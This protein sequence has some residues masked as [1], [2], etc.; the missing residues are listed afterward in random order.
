MCMGENEAAGE[1][2]EGSE[3]GGSA[4]D[5]FTSARSKKLATEGDSASLSVTEVGDVCS[6]TTAAG[7]TRL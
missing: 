6:G 4:S 5:G 2:G 1:D 3:T 7:C